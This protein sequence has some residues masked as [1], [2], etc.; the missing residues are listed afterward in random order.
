MVA[1]TG[2]S[3]VVIVD[4]AATS[5][6]LVSGLEAKVSD[7]LTTKLSYAVDYN[8]NP[9]VGAVGTD[10]LTRFTLVYGF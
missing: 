8:S 7:R 1:V 3:A 10:T 9:P 2:G 4:S 5:V 6:K